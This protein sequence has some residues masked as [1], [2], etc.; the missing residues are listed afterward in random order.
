MKIWSYDSGHDCN[1]AFALSGEPIAPQMT[2]LFNKDTA[3]F[4][5]S[6]I[7][8]NNVAQREIKKR[9]LDYWNST[10]LVTST[11]RAVDAVVSP[12][13][14]FPAARPGSYSYYG[15]TS[16]VNLL[17]YTS[18]V[19]PVTQVDK[20]VDLVEGGYKPLN[21]EDKISF[22]SCEF[23]PLLLQCVERG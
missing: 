12:V 16:W 9:Y 13:A 2:N 19:F 21:A 15:Y 8:A 1:T 20:E 4:T 22:E 18:V 3:Q 11:G 6:E 5:A 17:D 14:P 7:A 23:F 10:A